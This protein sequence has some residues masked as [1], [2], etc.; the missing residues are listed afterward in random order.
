MRPGAGGFSGAG[1][2]RLCSG[3]L[4]DGTGSKFHARGQSEFYADGVANA[5]QGCGN[6]GGPSRMLLQIWIIDLE[7]KDTGTREKTNCG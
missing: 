7:F 2:Q 4:Y 1:V 3:F 5:F 6:Q